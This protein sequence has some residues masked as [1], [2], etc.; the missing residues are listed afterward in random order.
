MIIKLSKIVAIFFVV[1][2][3]SPT[4]ATQQSIIFETDLFIIN[5]P[6]GFKQLQERLPEYKRREHEYAIIESDKERKKSI[7]LLIIAQTN[8][9]KNGDNNFTL[10]DFTSVLRKNHFQSSRSGNLSEIVKTTIGN[11]SALYFENNYQK[12]ILSQEK[13]WSV[14]KGDYFIIFYLAIPVHAENNLVNGIQEGIKK[15][16]L[17]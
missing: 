10:Y 14:I 6:N 3:S 16:K 8:V 12:G 15:V 4:H 13:F 1:L 11:S 5:L 2:Y 9:K 17:K 7:F